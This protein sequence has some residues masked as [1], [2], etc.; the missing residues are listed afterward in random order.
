MI[1]RLIT[2]V[3]LASGHFRDHDAE[4]DNNQDDCSLTVSHG[5]LRQ[6]LPLEA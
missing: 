3:S 4:G 1:C 5:A 6:V 2:T